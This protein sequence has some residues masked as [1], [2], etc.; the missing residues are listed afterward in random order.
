MKYEII[1]ADRDTA[2]D[3]RIE[4]E[5][6]S[7]AEAVKIAGKTVLIERVKPRP[8]RA[9]TG[10]ALPVVVSRVPRD[11]SQLVKSQREASLSPAAWAAIVGL[12][13]LTIVIA[14]WLIFSEPATVQATT[15]S[16]AA[17]PLPYVHP[18][19]PRQ[20]GTD[21][22]T[23]ARLIAAHETAEARAHAEQ[24]A[25]ERAQ[26]MR[27]ADAYRAALAAAAQQTIRPRSMSIGDVGR[28]PSETRIV[29]VIDRMRTLLS[30]DGKIVM[31]DVYP[32]TGL[33]DDSDFAS[34][35][36]FQ[37]TGTTQYETVM[38]STRTVFVL[39]P[40]MP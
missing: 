38:G 36:P 23:Y 19:V 14:A 29:Q 30:L 7:E 27:R 25:R 3:V 4:V 21:D 17:A 22:A 5:A 8:S 32:T 15:P 6:A 10:D 39:T 37:V 34:A 16:A 26:R 28:L 33:T 2:D 20:P 18:A 24:E 1:G 35:D 13:L 31:L 9:A 12:P 11:A 40:Y